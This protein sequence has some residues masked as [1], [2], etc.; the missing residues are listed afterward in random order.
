MA[1]GEVTAALGWPGEAGQWDPGLAGCR[2]REG[3][4]GWLLDGAAHYVLDGDV[5]DVLLVA[6]HTA[7]QVRVFE[8]EPRSDGVTRSAVTTMD[9]SRRLA[10]LRLDGAAGRPAG[11]DEDGLAAAR[12]LACLALA[13]EQAGAALRALEI[14]VAYTKQRVQFGRPIGS[15]QALAHRMADLHVRA[16]SA[17][18]V[19]LAA[20]QDISPARAAAARAY[21]SEALTLVASQM[22]QLHGAIGVTWEHTAH[23][24]FKRAHGA[25]LLLGSPSEHYSRIAAALLGG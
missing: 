25:G 16:E 4:G 2:A 22:I 12:D 1:S 13:A 5:A 6:A 15:F 10:V 11:C 20:A 19:C 18:S 21:C 3:T 7:D 9:S 24:Y 17:W 8:V 23:R 14:T